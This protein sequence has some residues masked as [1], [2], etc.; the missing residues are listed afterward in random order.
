MKKILL[1]TA[2]L[3]FIAGCTEDNEEVIKENNNVED[4]NETD[5]NKQLPLDERV[6]MEMNKDT[7]TIENIAQG[8]FDNLKI[9]FIRVFDE[10]GYEITSYSLTDELQSELKEYIK[11][12]SVK[13]GESRP[14]VHWGNDYDF[15]IVR[16]QLTTYEAD[17]HIGVSLDKKELAMTGG[18][19]ITPI[20]YKVLENEE[21]VFEKL[22]SY[23]KLS[24]EEIDSSN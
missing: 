24:T 22:E 16:P 17:V 12:I 20:V 4:L 23:F 18:F 6:R 14:G 21:E 13:K 11:S 7:N 1:T 3:T 2:L 5:N 15:I 10:S 19:L 8:Q 9:G